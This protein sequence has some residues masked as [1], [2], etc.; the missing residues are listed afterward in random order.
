MDCCRYIFAA[1]PKYHKPE[2]KAEV[3]WWEP[4]LAKRRRER[5]EDAS[6][7]YLAPSSYTS[8]TYVA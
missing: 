8:Q 7:V 4:W 5:G 3:A 6:V 1:D 2:V